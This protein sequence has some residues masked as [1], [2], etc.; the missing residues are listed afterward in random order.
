MKAIQI[1]QYKNPD[2]FVPRDVPVPRLKSGEVLVQIQ[3]AGV[4]PSDVANTQGYFPDHTTLPRIIG[5]DFVGKVVEGSSSLLGKI[6]MGSGGDIGFT[7]D[8]TFAEYLVVPEKGAVEV[9]AGLGLTHAAILGVPFLA[10]LACLNRFPRNLQTK[11]LLLIGGTGA[12]G[13]AATVIAQE[14]GAEVIRT[15]LHP[16]DINRLA[17]ALQKG[18][19]M[20]LGKND[21]IIA[22]TRK[23]TKDQGFDL[24]IN[25]VGGKTFDPALKSLKKFGAMACIASPGQPRVEFSLLDFYR[26]NISLYGLNTILDGV[27]ASA[28]RLRELF[29]EFVGKTENLACLG[30][31]EIMPF[32]EAKTILEKALAKELRK[33]VFK[34]LEE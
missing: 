24:I 4:N 12:V 16:S 13:S 10:A 23:L 17:P 1:H 2:D 14:R 15:I 33:P 9:P 26:R 31:T 18:V 32:S 20:D 5:R 21:D 30:L 19:F 3:Y 7:R 6:V 11:S 27:V 22:Q 28:E 8:G 29:A 34:M 25:L